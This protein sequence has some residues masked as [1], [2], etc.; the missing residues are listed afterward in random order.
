MRAKPNES[1]RRLPPKVL[2]AEIVSAPHVGQLHA[3]GVEYIVIALRQEAAFLARKSLEGY[4]LSKRE[5][6]MLGDIALALAMLD[7]G[8]VRNAQAMLAA[9]RQP[10]Q[11]EE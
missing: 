7:K 10:E 3:E 11:L 5:G 8:V 6:K 4:K 2:R 1:L 9:T